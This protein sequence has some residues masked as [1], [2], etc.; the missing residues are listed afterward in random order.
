MHVGVLARRTAVVA[1]ALLCAAVGAPPAAV[2]QTDAALGCAHT[3]APDMPGPVGHANL[4]QVTVRECAYA[5][6]TLVVRLRNGSSSTFTE[7][8]VG[9]SCD[10]TGFDVVCGR[11]APSTAGA[12]LGIRPQCPNSGRLRLTLVIT[13]AEGNQH[14]GGPRSFPCARPPVR[15]LA[16]PARQSLASALRRGV[17]TRF[18][19][20]VRCTAK[21]SLLADNAAGDRVGTATLRR[22]RAGTTV[23]RVRIKPAYRRLY[24]RRSALVTVSVTITAN[25]GER[26]SLG[27]HVRLR[28]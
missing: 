28:R 21:V 2:A 25:T 11:G 3:V 20:A 6:N 7:P 27:H 24:R 4:L 8:P 15:V 10:D 1:A 26:V 16:P 23:A 13:D 22:T 18:S 9:F 17:I 14:V 5:W 19:C 12:D